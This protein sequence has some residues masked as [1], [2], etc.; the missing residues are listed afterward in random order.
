MRELRDIAAAFDALAPGEVA[1]LATVV[2]VE[3]STYRRAGARALVL[4]DERV[5][6]L[7]SGGCLEGDLVLR[8]REVSA[9]RAAERV[10]YD[11][12]GEDDL[13]WGLGLGCAGLVD[14]LLQPVSREAPGPLPRLR[15]ALAG[16]GPAL[17]ATVVAREGEAAPALGA[18]AALSSGERAA[19][20]ASGLRARTRWR[21][22][23][24]FRVE[25]LE[26]RIAPPTT[27]VVFGAGPDA[28]PVVRLA[29]ALGYAVRV[30]DPRPGLARPERFPEADAIVACEPD[31]AVSRSGVTPNDVA[32]VMTHHYLHDRAIL[33]AL[34]EAPPRYVGVLG[35]KRRTEDLVRDLRESGRAPAPEA[36][37]RLHAPAGLDVGA[38]GADE[39]A[40]ALL[41]EA[42]AVLAGRR[43]GPLR[44]RKGPIH[45]P[46]P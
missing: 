3:G 36:L 26:E 28:A 19:L 4:P 45:E 12:R 16:P 21:E 9:R 27:L 29:A 25:L 7:L 39:I 32:I 35:P 18:E 8:A 22:G 34:L 40:L 44:E 11:H 23:Q 13:L 17:V 6:G 41:A 1:V 10:R 37:E 20:E 14:V 42:T 33:G 38:D 15:E 46:A 2:Y 31:D 30:V 24:G 5:V 43:G